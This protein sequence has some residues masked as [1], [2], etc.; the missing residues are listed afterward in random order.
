[1]CQPK[2]TPM[3]RLSCLT[4][5]TRALVL[6]MRAY[7]APRGEA[8]SPP[9]QLARRCRRHAHV[10]SAHDSNTHKELAAPAAPRTRVAQRRLH[11]AAPPALRVDVP[12]DVHLADHELESPPLAKDGDAVHRG[13]RVVRE[14]VLAHGV[15]ERKVLVAL[16]DE[17]PVRAACMH[18]HISRT[19]RQLAAQCA[20]SWHL[21]EQ[22]AMECPS[23]RQSA[24]RRKQWPVDRHATHQGCWRGAAPLAVPRPLPAPRSSSACLSCLPPLPPP[25]HQCTAMTGLRGH[26]YWPVQCATFTSMRLPGLAPGA[27]NSAHDQVSTCALSQLLPLQAYRAMQHRAS[28][29]ALLTNSRTMSLTSTQP[30]SCEVGSPVPPGSLAA[31]SL[32][33]GAERILCLAS[34]CMM[35]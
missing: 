16:V 35:Q 34:V 33:T 9:G 4:P 22:L 11:P 2:P 12:Q 25:L 10:C 18:V 26:L 24:H 3:S 13:A 6:H 20:A 8:R 23:R 17:P 31:C 5:A 19:Q 7:C 30:T 27:E 32:S 21:L 1:M 15:R 14:K 28:S 29:V